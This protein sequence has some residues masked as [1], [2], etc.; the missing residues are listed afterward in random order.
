[1]ED[2]VARDLYYSIKSVVAEH[3]RIPILELIFDDKN[4]SITPA[5]SDQKVVD[6][7]MESYRV[8]NNI[9]ERYVSEEGP[10]INVGTL[11]EHVCAIAR[12]TFTRKVWGVEGNE[13]HN[14]LHRLQR[15]VHVVKLNTI[16]QTHMD[17][18]L[19]EFIALVL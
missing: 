10:T 2:H 19:N 17:D 13:M 1:M 9:Q 14:G 3:S 5:Y 15:D 16:F 6:T 18:F 12:V 8:E 11:Y 4:K 7:V